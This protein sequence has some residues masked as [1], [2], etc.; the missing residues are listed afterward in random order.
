MLTKNLIIDD[1]DISKLSLSEPKLT[2]VSNL[3]DVEVETVADLKTVGTDKIQRATVTP[4]IKDGK[5]TDVVI[6][7]PGQGYRF[8]PTITIAGS[9]SGA[10][11]L[12]IIDG[13]GKITSVT[14]ISQGTYYDSNTILTVRN[15]LY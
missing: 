4:V 7:N 11:L 6:T 2:T 14:V 1:K 10:E 15:L 3:Y 13:A 8:P 9:G 5:I 12:P